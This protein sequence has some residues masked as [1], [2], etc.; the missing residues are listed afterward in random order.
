MVLQESLKRQLDLG[1][2]DS[3][4]ARVF[5]LEEKRFFSFE[6]DFGVFV[7]FAEAVAELDEFLEAFVLVL[8]ERKH[9][10]HVVA[11]ETRSLAHLRSEVCEHLGRVLVQRANVGHSARLVVLEIL[12]VVL[13]YLVDVSGESL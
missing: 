6:V 3:P 2:V 12:R 1:G 9:P 5:L 8:P 4:L 13:A 7:G 10:L 11:E